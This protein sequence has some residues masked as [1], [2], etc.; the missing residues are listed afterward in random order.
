[1]NTAANT[2]DRIP[3]NANHSRM[4]QRMAQGHLIRKGHDL[5]GYHTVDSENIWHLTRTC[6]A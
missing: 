4:D 2:A 5:K 1:M 3:F 6:C